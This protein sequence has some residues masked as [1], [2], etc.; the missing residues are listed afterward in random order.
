MFA[1]PIFFD[2]PFSTVAKTMVPALR[3]VGSIS[4]RVKYFYE[5]QIIIQG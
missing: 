5:Q 4:S 2:D 1:E 3:D